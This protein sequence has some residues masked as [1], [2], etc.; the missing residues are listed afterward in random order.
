[1]QTASPMTLTKD[2]MIAALRPQLLPQ[3]KPEFLRD[4]LAM[5]R[6]AGHN[7][8]EDFRLVSREFGSGLNATISGAAWAMRQWIAKRPKWITDAQQAHREAF[9]A[10]LEAVMRGEWD[11][12]FNQTRKAA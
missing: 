9:L 10:D 5:K 11:H 6:A 4:V 2:G 8:A 3:T 12:L 7:D 1:M